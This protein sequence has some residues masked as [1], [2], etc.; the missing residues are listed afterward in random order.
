MN[1]REHLRTEGYAQLPGLT[2]EP[3]VSAAL[4]AIEADLRDNY[5]PS[6]QV[7]Y[8]NQSY[9][10]DLRGTPAI[11]GLLQKS[12]AL[13]VLDDLLGLGR[14]HWNGGQIA[15]RKAHNHPAP[16]PP[17]PHLDGFSSGLN[18]LEPGRIYSHTL[19]AGVFL[20]PVR[21]P[22]AGNFTVWPQ[23]HHVYQR[24]FQERGRR[25]LT[26]PMPRPPLGEPVQIMCEPG[27]VVLAH[28]LL[29]HT[30]AVNVS[31]ADRV[32]VFFRVVL[33]S[34]ESDRWNYLINPWKGWKIQVV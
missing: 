32:A 27:D 30:A 12:P 34:V 23:S 19:L 33:R 17:E 20:T 31:D 14:I 10:P 3:L 4:T 11:T 9:C 28:Y 6:R 25:A 22:F 21:S 5:D 29:G 15:I 26:E 1:W 7:E 24:Y 8:D 13:A 16:I 2:P 18:A